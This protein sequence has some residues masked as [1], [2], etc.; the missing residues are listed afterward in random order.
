V[1]TSIGL[2]LK[3]A[4]ENARR[5]PFPGTPQQASAWFV[6]DRAAKALGELLVDDAGALRPV[7]EAMVRKVVGGR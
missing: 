4:I 1:L 2:D 7:V 3:L 6:A 5:M